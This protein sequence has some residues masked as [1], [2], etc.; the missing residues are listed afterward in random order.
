M[1]MAARRADIHTGPW[2]QAGY[3]STSMHGRCSYMCI[4]LFYKRVGLPNPLLTFWLTMVEIT[5]QPRILTV[6][7]RRVTGSL[8]TIV[9]EL[10]LPVNL[11][12]VNLGHLL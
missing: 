3:M 12:P 7:T 8:Y 2:Q 5:S 9:I 6:D 1:K 11:P 4:I 10:S